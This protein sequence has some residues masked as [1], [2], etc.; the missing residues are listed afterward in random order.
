MLSGS[1]TV[2]ICGGECMSGLRITT[3][4]YCGGNVVCIVGMVVLQ[5][6]AA[7]MGYRGMDVLMD[8]ISCFRLIFT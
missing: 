6:D 7:I 8:Q 1:G 5:I 3:W 2:E 4:L